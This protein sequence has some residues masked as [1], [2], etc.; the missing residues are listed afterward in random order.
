M[1]DTKKNA[2]TIFI[3]QGEKH[4]LEALRFLLEQQD[5][6]AMAGEARSAE[7]LLTQVC[8]NAP[9]VVLLDWNLPGI[10][11]QRLVRALRECC[12]AAKLI[13]L[14]V[15]PEHEAAAKEYGMDGFL[16]QQ[17]SAEQFLTALNAVR[18]TDP[19]GLGDL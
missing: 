2:T 4:V 3:A 9:D 10:H 17:L 13:A 14:S 19:K 8:K 5:D 7:D 6:I 18:S 12:P 16:S 11:H 15:K 1:N